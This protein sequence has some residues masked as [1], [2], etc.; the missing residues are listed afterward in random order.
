MRKDK[1]TIVL[2]ALLILVLLALLGVFGYDLY[3]AKK[4]EKNVEDV[5]KKLDEIIV[6][7]M[8]ENSDGEN[9][10]DLNANDNTDTQN[11]GAVTINN[12]IVYGKIEIPSVGIKYPV[13]EF[14]YDTLKYNVCN[15]SKTPINGTSNLCLAG[16]NTSNGSLFGKLKRVK[17]GDIIEVTN[18]YGK[19]YTYIIYSITA[20]NPEDNSL[21]APTEKPIVS[22]ITCTNGD[23]QR[24]I[25][26]G[27]L[28]EVK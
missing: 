9:S 13:V 15:I 28:L 27:Q 25:V 24:L 10:A 5:L 6:I 1:V 20:V 16:H 2:T 4:T 14:N 3:Q 18:I 23:R 8:S 19:R 21:L 11:K 17:N 26:Q 7:N 12:Y 22:L